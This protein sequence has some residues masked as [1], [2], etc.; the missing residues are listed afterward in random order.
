MI[1]FTGMILNVRLPY[2]VTSKELLKFMIEK[3][4]PIIIYS[5]NKDILLLKL[6]YLRMILLT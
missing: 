6:I 3:N 4:C 1:K 2:T 5:E